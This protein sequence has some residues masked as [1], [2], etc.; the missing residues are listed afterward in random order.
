M[1]SQVFD[2]MRDSLWQFVGAVLA[3]AAIGLTLWLAVRRTH[4][5]AYEY[6]V[7]SLVTVSQVIAD[8]VQVLFRG[9]PIADVN[10]AL[11]RALDSGRSPVRPA[12]FEEPIRVRFDDGGLLGIEIERRVPNN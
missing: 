3:A 7:N 1:Q 11:V 2:F 6:R 9:R 8:Q 10:L 4:A 5:L 12:D